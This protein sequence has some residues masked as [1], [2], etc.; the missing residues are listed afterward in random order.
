MSFLNILFSHFATRLK[1]PQK[2][3]RG[4]EITMS[5]GLKND[6]RIEPEFCSGIGEQTWLKHQI[7][8]S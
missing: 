8:R 2:E 1:C 7:R 4:R 6:Q 5:N 3:R